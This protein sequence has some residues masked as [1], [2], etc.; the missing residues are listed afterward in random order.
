LDNPPS[1]L[2]D[3]IVSLHKPYLRPIVRGKENRPVDPDRDRD[4]AK[5]HILQVD[6]LIFI[7]KLDF[8]VFNECTYQTYALRGQTQE[9]FRSC[10]P[11]RGGQDLFNKQ[12]QELL[13][14][15]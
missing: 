5:A 1:A 8:N 12:K 7:D 13:Y 11:A 4:G 6:G 15:K 2:K 14:C 3:R 9:I 10:K